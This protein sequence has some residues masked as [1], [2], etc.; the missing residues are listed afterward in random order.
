MTMAMMKMSCDPFR[1]GG[2]RAYQ[3]SMFPPSSS[4]YRRFVVAGL[5]ILAAGC[6]RSGLDLVPVTGVVQRGGTPLSQV[7]VNSFPQSGPMATGMT[8]SQGRFSL[9]TSGKRGAVPGNHVLVLTPPRPPEGFAMPGIGEVMTKPVVGGTNVID[10]ALQTA[11]ES[12][13]KFSVESGASKTLT[14]D[15]QSKTMK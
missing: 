12:P 11:E 2:T 4:F 14:V 6:G 9:S 1:Q 13:L 8:D 5:L 10:A 3:R 15:V 7:Q